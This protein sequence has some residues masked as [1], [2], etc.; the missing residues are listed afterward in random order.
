MGTFVEWQTI[1]LVS[2]T[3]FPF[4]AVIILSLVPE[5]PS[6]LLTQN[7]VKDAEKAFRW[8]RGRSSDAQT[9]LGGL[10]RKHEMQ[11]KEEDASNIED[12]S[13]A[14]LKSNIMKSEFYKPLGIVLL[15]FFVMQFSGVNSVAFYTVSLMKS[16]AGDGNEYISMI[17]IDTIRVLA[18]F[19]ACI[20]LRMCYRRTL[21]MISGIGTSVCLIAVA[22]CMYFNQ[23]NLQNFNFS[24]LSMVFLI[25]YI[26]FISIGLFPLPWV[27]QG[28]ILQQATRGFSSGVTTC[29]NF[30]C[31][32][33]VVKTFVDLSAAIGISGVFVVYAGIGLIGTI[34]L[35]II[36][37][38]TKNRT[39]QEIEDGF[40]RN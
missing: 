30:I 27:L 2:A 19:I 40:S 9:E 29:F 39:L 37:P 31:F 34:A 35:Y 11:R 12:D 20:L 23:I 36:L 3:I 7:R 38:E 5:S 21:L 13:V 32:F 15:F 26:C 14:K 22:I 28:E 25:G 18:A 4:I 8:L 6:W 16:I 10:I 17:I 1:A 24:T 33:I